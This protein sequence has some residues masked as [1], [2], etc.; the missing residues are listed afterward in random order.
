MA[1]SLDTGIP[2]WLQRNW[3]PRETFDPT[4]WLQERYRRQVQAQTLPL[5]IQGMAL[6]N[7][8]QSLAIEHQGMLNDVQGMQLQQYQSEAPR[9]QEL[10]KQYATDPV[11]MMNHVESFQS[12]IVQKQWIEA[13]TAA[14]HSQIA[15]AAAEDIKERTAATARLMTEGTQGLPPMQREPDGAP[16]WD[17]IKQASESQAAT[18][19]SLWLARESWRLGVAGAG[20]AP[21][22]QTVDYN[23][24]KVS[25]L[26][27][28]KTGHFQSMDSLVAQGTTAAD[29]AEISMNKERIA[30]LYKL[31]D[32]IEPEEGGLK[33]HPNTI[34]RMR[35]M[36]QIQQL[37]ERNRA[38][39]AGGVPGATGEEPLLQ[40]VPG[41]GIV[42]VEPAAEPVPPEPPPEEP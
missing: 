6:Q 8:A 35:I 18:K 37:K 11:G 19:Q 14:S 4:P 12:P 3:A 21:N 15:V 41:K 38:L 25:V 20:I 31:H 29:K 2:P 39:D 13:Q 42:P 23:G 30:Q 33:S 16:S 27:N 10:I 7:Q 17:W 26:V 1:D 9:L 22:V 5:Q 36:T 34:K 32:A 28:P 24:K 40:F